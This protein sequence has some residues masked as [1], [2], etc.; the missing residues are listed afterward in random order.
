MANRLVIK[1][2]D[3]LLAHTIPFA[4]GSCNEAATTS[5]AARGRSSDDEVGAVRR[6]PWVVR[7]PQDAHTR[8]LFAAAGLGGMLER[9]T[10]RPRPQHKAADSGARP[11]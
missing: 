10:L 5:T 3:R 11:G 6:R 7:P 9:E 1:K 4:V 8:A 2:V